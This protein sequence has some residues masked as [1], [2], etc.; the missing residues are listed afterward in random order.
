MRVHC[1]V[2]TIL[3]VLCTLHNTV[4]R[5]SESNVSS[6]GSVSFKRTDKDIERGV[7]SSI[8]FK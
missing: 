5:D 6:R 8:Q 3:C 4:Q 7:K 2:L 1:P